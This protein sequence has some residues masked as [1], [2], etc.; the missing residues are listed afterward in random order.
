MKVHSTYLI[1]KILTKNIKIAP[2]R[3]IFRL[4]WPLD[5][6]AKVN[7]DALFIKRYFLII[8]KPLKKPDD[9]LKELKKQLNLD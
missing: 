7:Y 4:I 3:P 2:L 6:N 8:Y 9:S 5:D 1:T